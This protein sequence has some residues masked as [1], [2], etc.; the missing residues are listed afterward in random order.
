M[1]PEKAPAS[2]R[3]L[4]DDGG[5]TSEQRCGAARGQAY[6]NLPD[7]TQR[8]RSA[9]QFRWTVV[10]PKWLA[11]IAAD[12][13]VP[14]HVYKTAFFLAALANDKT[15][16]V[17]PRANKL[18]RK[19]GYKPHLVTEAIKLLVDRGHMVRIAGHPTSGPVPKYYRLVVEGGPDPDHH[20]KPGEQP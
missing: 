3:R 19:L 2:R 1:A 11:Q 12:Q 8:P 18:A 6:T 16:E 14:F 13:D 5:R 9:D 10:R 7:D 4:R 17:W 15:H 20:H